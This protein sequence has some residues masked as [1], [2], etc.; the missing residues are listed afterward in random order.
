MARTQ[1]ACVPVARARLRTPPGDVSAGV[2]RP[3]DVAARP[4]TRRVGA[5][6]GRVAAGRGFALCGLALGGLAL[7]SLAFLALLALL[8]LGLGLDDRGGDGRDHGLVRVVEERDALERRQVLEPERVAHLHRADVGLDR[9]GHFHRQRLDVER[10]GRLRENAAL[11]HAG[12]VLATVQVNLHGRLDHDVEPDFLQV[13]VAHVPP[14]RVALVLLQDRGVHLGLHPPARRRA[15][16]A[17]PRVPSAPSEA[18]ARRRRTPARSSSR[19]GRRER[20]PACAGVGTRASRA[21]HVPSPRDEICRR[22]RRRI[23]AD[24][25]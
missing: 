22:P 8:G 19:R 11:L 20:T 14:D 17:A 25:K 24:A 13:D 23:V 18:H 9:L 7:D 3:A 10:R 15:P 2:R 4:T 21:A 12:C 1:G 6:L 5:G 16:R